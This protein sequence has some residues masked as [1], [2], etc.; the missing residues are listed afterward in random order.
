MILTNSAILVK[1]ELI[2]KGSPTHLLQI[3]KGNSQSIRI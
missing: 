2:N 3:L 1:E